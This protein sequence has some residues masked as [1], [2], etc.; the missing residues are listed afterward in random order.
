MQFTAGKAFI[1]EQRPARS[2]GVAKNIL[3]ALRE[4]V[5][6]DRNSSESKKY[7]SKGNGRHKPQLLEAYGACQAACE[8]RQ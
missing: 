7:D 6:D 2:S 3:P 8:K 5:V 1:R 4:H